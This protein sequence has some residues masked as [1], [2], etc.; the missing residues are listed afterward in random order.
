MEIL[1]DATKAINSKMKGKRWVEET[2]PII[3]DVNKQI[4]GL[5][6]SRDE[7]SEPFKKTL[8]DIND[9]WKPALIPLNEIDSQLR[10]R[11]MNEYEGNET[12]EGE[13]GKL[14]FPESWGYEVID[15]KLVPKE[16]RM[17]VVDKKKI[18]EEIGKGLRKIKGLE[19]K[20]IRSLRVLTESK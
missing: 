9:R 11:V 19:I 6:R 16:Y 17:E 8:K 18:R 20:P 5:E 7:E 14:V 3:I 10:E 2:L 15:F 4:K 1:A 13:S 12:I